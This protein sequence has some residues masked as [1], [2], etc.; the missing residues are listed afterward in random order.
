MHKKAVRTTR[1]GVKKRVSRARS[2]ASTR[3]RRRSAATRSMTLNTSDRRILGL[4]SEVIAEDQ[5]LLRR[6]AE[7]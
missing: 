2:R 6:L 7:R 1:S 5:G 4:A 3:V